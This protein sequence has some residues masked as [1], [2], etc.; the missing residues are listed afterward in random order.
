[1]FFKVPIIC[2]DTLLVLSTE[3]K[4]R[5]DLCLMKPLAKLNLRQI[6]I[7]FLMFPTNLMEVDGSKKLIILSSH[8][9][10]SEFLQAFAKARHKTKQPPAA[11]KM[12]NA[13]HSA[14]RHQEECF[15]A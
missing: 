2:M 1:M 4:K 8:V 11:L 6:T 3:T 14:T 13:A 5:L 10:I 7:C 9:I 12:M 15:E